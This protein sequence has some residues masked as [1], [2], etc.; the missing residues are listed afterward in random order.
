VVSILSLPL[1]ETSERKA[2]VKYSSEVRQQELVNLVRQLE[3]TRAEYMKC[4]E[5]LVKLSNAEYAMQL[6]EI[7]KLL[8]Q[9]TKQLQ[10]DNKELEHIQTK[11]MN[12]KDI[13]DKHVL[14]Q[15]IVSLNMEIK[16][17]NEQIKEIKE[18]LQNKTSQQQT[19]RFFSIKERWNKLLREANE[20][21]NTIKRD[22]NEEYKKLQATKSNIEKVINLLRTRY[23]NTMNEYKQRILHTKL[24]IQ[25]IKDLVKQ[26]SMYFLK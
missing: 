6:Q 18:G 24:Q 22:L 20:S 26:K 25:R 1:V 23:K 7:N 13:D 11:E 19:S 21:P 15:E 5:R 4:K 12:T 2:L 10:K 8:T 17:V 9:K 16:I 3:Y 14:E